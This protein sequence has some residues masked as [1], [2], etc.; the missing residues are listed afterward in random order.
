MEPKPGCLADARQRAD[1]EQRQPTST[2]MTRLARLDSRLDGAQRLRGAERRKDVTAGAWAP[3]SLS[4]SCVATL[5]EAAATGVVYQ[6]SEG[7]AF[8]YFPR[9]TDHTINW[10]SGPGGA[11]F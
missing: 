11:I 5:V 6:D 7:T 4:V 8:V 10:R 9:T 1:E 3:N 2:T